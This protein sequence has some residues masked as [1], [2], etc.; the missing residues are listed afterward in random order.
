MTE[1][2]S[3]VE[4]MDKHIVKPRD[5]YKSRP[6]L[7]PSEASVT[8]MLDGRKHTIGHCNRASTTD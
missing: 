1:E 2:F 5:L 6:G 8:Y 3:L 4:A 7:Y